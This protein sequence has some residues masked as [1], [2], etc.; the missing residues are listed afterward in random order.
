M[1]T[2]R[3]NQTSSRSKRMTASKASRPPSNRTTKSSKSRRQGT[4]TQQQH[5]NP[6]TNNEGTLD[7]DTDINLNHSD[8]DQTT[9]EE[10]ISDRTPNEQNEQPSKQPKTF[11]SRF[12]DLDLETFH[13][14]LDDWTLVAL[15]E[16]NA[17]QAPKGTR[18]STEIRSLVKSI[19]LNYEK[20]MLMAALMGGLHEVVVWNLV[21]EG[22]KNAHFN[23]WIRFL[24]FGNLALDE[25]LPKKEDTTGWAAR[26]RK[27][28]DIWKGLT[29]DEK[30]V[31]RNPYFFALANLPD[32]SNV[33]DAIDNAN[34]DNNDNPTFS[35]LEG[36][37]VAPQVH[38]LTEAEKSKYQPIFNRIIDVEKLHV[39]HGKPDPTQSIATLQK[40]SLA[41]LKKAHHDR[42]QITYYATAV[43]C[44]DTEGWSQTYSNNTMFAR[45][46]SNNMKIPGKLASYV[47][48]K[49]T[50][51]EI[52]CSKLQ[53]PSDERRTKLG[54]ILN[55]LVDAQLPKCIFPKKTDPEGEIK[56]K[57]WPIRIV[58]HAGSLLKKSDLE[59]GHHL[60]RDAAVKCWLDDIENKRFTIESIPESELFPDNSDDE[61]APNP[62]NDETASTRNQSNKRDRQ[63]RACMN[64]GQ[65][66]KRKKNRKNSTFNKHGD[67]GNLDKTTRKK[68]KG[69]MRKKLKLL[70][71]GDKNLKRPY[72]GLHGDEDFAEDKNQDEDSDQDS[73]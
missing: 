72:C 51:E 49:S 4:N 54:R 6:G 37:T 34:L 61:Q 63:H 56:K 14:H 66:N 21:G 10:P 36:S 48:G 68:A 9:R 27:V 50:A 42:Y 67:L 28:A 16:A 15:R 60:V 1:P 53:Q 7:K 12:P 55:D 25:R 69:S 31:F 40:N 35:H 26:N 20:Q 73:E 38:P 18:A 17:K 58:Q 57:G 52:E 30:D 70:A 11:I 43:S 22:A 41:A 23:P 13:D 8:E 46:A 5:P 29:E 39:C 64:A 19:R 45:W 65:T 62:D 44:G 59:R 2:T 33:P 71:R 3:S 47:H 24:A 32:L